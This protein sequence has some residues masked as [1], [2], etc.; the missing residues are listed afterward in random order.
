MH[1]GFKEVLPVFEVGIDIED[2]NRFK[3]Y[4]LEK[5][6]YFLESIFSKE[7]LDYCFSKPLPAKHLAVRFCAKEAFIKA[8]SGKNVQLKHFEI[9]IVNDINGK[10]QIHL[11]KQYNY[12]ESKISLSHEKDKA[13]AFVTVEGE[14]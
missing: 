10:P 13:I 2:I 6:S 12:L 4:S 14:K 9:K 1:A 8:V 5:D 3:K 7:E 11:P